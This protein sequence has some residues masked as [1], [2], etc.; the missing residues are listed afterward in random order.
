MLV[1][2]H[3]H[4]YRD[5]V[6]PV[7]YRA[8]DLIECAERAQSLGIKELAFTPHLSRFVEA[9]P[10][11]RPIEEKTHPEVRKWL[12]E[13]RTARLEEY[14]RVVQEVQAQGFPVKLGL[15]VDYFPQAEDLIREILGDYPWDYV[16]GAVH[17]IDDFAVDFSKEI[18]W[19]E[20]DVNQVYIDYT[21]LVIS[22]A[23]SGLFDALAHVDLVKKF[24]ARPKNDLG[25]ELAKECAEEFK[26]A[27][28]AVEVNAAG[29]R[30]PVKE[31][32]PSL[33]ILFLCQKEGV[34][35][36]LGSDGHGRDEVGL[37]VSKARTWAEQAGYSEVSTF[38]Q[39][40]RQSQPL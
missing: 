27:G 18:G 35:I 3:F 12:R 5:N 22:A 23:H 1:D 17:F 37:L 30:K 21:Q 16:L 36:V 11:F 31:I 28:V 8:A 2:Y 14:V 9:E 6:G 40:Q 32:Y 34:P 26:K 38:I 39:R 19:P 4:I 15:E 13:T 24:G 33:A 20:R 7:S 10:L 29:L 25:L